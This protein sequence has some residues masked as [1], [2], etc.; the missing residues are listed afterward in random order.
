[1]AD[2]L[3]KQAKTLRPIMQIGKNGV[4]DGTIAQ[5]EHELKT[6]HLVKVKLLKAGASTKD[7]RAA[8]ASLLAERTN[9]TIV[10]LVGGIVVFHRR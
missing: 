9:A 7:E 5:L 10:D 4:T 6:K 1:M 3:K 2:P 8:I